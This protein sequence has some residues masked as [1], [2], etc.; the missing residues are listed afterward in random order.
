MFTC[1]TPE[2]IA[3]QIESITARPNTE[4][5]ICHFRNCVI[6]NLPVEIHQH[7]KKFYVVCM[8][9]IKPVPGL[10]PQNTLHQKVL[11][12]SLIHI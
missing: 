12:L 3:I 11:D 9:I 4:N 8:P 5:H 7:D 2:T 6:R 10:H 1:P